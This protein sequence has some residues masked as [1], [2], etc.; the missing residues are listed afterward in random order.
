M[1]FNELGLKSLADL[2]A[3][4]EAGRLS[5]LKGFG[6]KTEDSI[7]AN[8]DQATEQAQR[9][10]IDVARAVAEAI[11]E[12]LQQLPEVKQVAVAGSCRRRRE[13]CGDLMCWRLAPTP[14]ADG[15]TG[16]ASA[17][18]DCSAAR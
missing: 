2:K 8:I 12:D 16:V 15:S 7:L 1:F 10:G 17:G 4:C 11:V 3:A 5:K 14:S 6:K 9:V 18:R 13:S